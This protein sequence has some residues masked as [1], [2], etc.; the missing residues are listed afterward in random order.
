VPVVVNWLLPYVA[1]DLT[2]KDGRPSFTKLLIAVVVVLFAIGKPLPWWLVLAVIAAS[3]GRSTF[4][5]FL[6]SKPPGGP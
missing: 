6:N 4:T 1:L 2:G 5:A 3:F